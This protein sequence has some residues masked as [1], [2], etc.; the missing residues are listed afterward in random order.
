MANYDWREFEYADWRERFPPDRGF[1]G[2]EQWR[3]QPRPETWAAEP[4]WIDGIT[5][6]QG[7]VSL[8]KT[9][10]LFISH[11]QSDESEARKV[12]SWAS[13]AGF[14]YWLDVL[15]PNLAG[16]KRLVDNLTLEQVAM[17]V[18]VI[19]EMALLN[20]THILVVLSQATAKSRWVPYEYG[21]AKDS[22]VVSQKASSWLLP[23]VSSSNVAEYVHLGEKF[24]DASQVQAWLAREARFWSLQRNLGS[25]PAA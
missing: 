11:K 9:P 17:A 19:I 4:G 20:S 3:G 22:T 18:A 13:S 16:L 14:E 15:D 5:A 6:R 25:E 10:R 23:G 8:P 12:A 21:R 1:L 2:I 24:R 7:R